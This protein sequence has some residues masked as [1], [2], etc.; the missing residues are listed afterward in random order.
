MYDCPASSASNRTLTPLFAK[1][2]IWVLRP[3][4]PAQDLE[5]AQTG[6]S[7]FLDTLKRQHL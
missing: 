6:I 7:H 2:V 4:T 1:R 5:V 3:G